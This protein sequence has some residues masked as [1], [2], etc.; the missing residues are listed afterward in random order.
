[1][2]RK[3]A[4]IHWEEALEQLQSSPSLK[5]MN[6]AMRI[7]RLIISSVRTAHEVIARQLRLDQCALDSLAFF[8]PWDLDTNRPRVVIDYA[9]TYL[10]A[11]WMA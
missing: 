1:L 7:D 9:E 8:V 10:E 11:V 6:N 5:S 2:R 4:G 3:I